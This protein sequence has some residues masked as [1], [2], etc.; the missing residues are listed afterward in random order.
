MGFL[1]VPPGSAVMKSTGSFGGWG[2]G[3]KHSSSLWIDTEQLN[4]KHNMLM[5]F[6]T[7]EQFPIK[8]Y[9]I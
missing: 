3:I 1:A 2:G 5:S 9:G 8:H 7:T 4:L 6:K